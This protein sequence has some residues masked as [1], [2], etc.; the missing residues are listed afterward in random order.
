MILKMYSIRDIKADVYRQ[1]FF[2]R[3]DVDAVR[4]VSAMV[5]EAGNQLNMYPDDFSLLAI[6]EFNDENAAVYSYEAD[7]GP[8]LIAECNQMFFEENR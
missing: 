8:K 5:N 1:P 2:A 4:M 3:N 7:G 6:A